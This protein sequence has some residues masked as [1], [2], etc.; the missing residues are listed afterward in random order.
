MK[1][2]VP[3]RF[4]GPLASGNGGYSAAVFAEAIAGPAAVSLR[5]PV[6]LDR[7]LRVERGEEGTQI[8]DGETVVALVEAV[9][10]LA[11]GVPE[12]VSVE[13]A[14]QASEGYRGLP[15]G[16]FCRCFVCGRAREDS[17]EVFAG[18]VEGHELVASPWAPPAWAADSAGNAR[19]EVVAGVLDCPTYFAAYMHDELRVSFLARFQLRFDAPVG[20]GEEHVVI[21]WPIETEGRKLHAGSAVLAADGTVRAMAQALLIEPRA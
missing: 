18:L 2:S 19:P 3:A 4:N 11:L 20:V 17:L 16:E 8:L 15:D 9:P 10:E 12:P 1:V 6:P 5:S 14:R 21:A 13:E 7:E